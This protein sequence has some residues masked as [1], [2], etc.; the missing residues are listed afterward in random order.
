MHPDLV[1]C[2]IQIQLDD[3]KEFYKKNNLRINENPILPYGSAEFFRTALEQTVIALRNLHEQNYK[4]AIDKIRKESKVS[5]LVEVENEIKFSFIE[6][7]KE[8]TESW[9]FLF[10]GLKQQIDYITKKQA[11]TTNDFPK[12]IITGFN[13]NLD[14]DQLETLYKA[15][16]K[17]YIECSLDDF[18]AIFTEHPKPIKWIDKGGTRHEPNKQ[19]IFEFFYLLKENNYLK[20]PGIDLDLTGTNPNN[21]YKKL[22]FIFPNI[23]NF[24]NS[25]KFKAE[26]NTPRKKELKIIIQS[27]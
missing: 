1:A 25:N 14:I 26:Q 10:N 8:I 12:N 23:K 13:T 5:D 22:K 9:C 17:N 6:N 2:N 24:P 19:T 11:I 21:F 16:S 7:R 15:L 3:R 4:D 18:K 20:N 27:L